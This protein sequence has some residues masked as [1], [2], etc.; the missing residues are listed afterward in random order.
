MQLYHQVTDMA[1][2]AMNNIESVD[3]VNCVYISIIVDSKKGSV[4]TAC[5]AKYRGRRTQGVVSRARPRQT[6]AS[7]RNVIGHLH[8]RLSVPTPKSITW[9]MGVTVNKGQAKKI[10][11]AGNHLEGHPSFQG[12]PRVQGEINICSVFGVAPVGDLTR[13]STSR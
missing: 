3:N 12:S 8:V 1:L 11:H 2:S 9:Y 4:K 10:E 5:C 7:E 6:M 13:G